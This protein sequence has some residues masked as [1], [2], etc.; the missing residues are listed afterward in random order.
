[1]A[2][3]RHYFAEKAHSG[4]MAPWK[5]WQRV[6]VIAGLAGAVL[7]LLAEAPGVH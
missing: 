2:A 6:A 4:T 5:P 1:M 3:I 7:L